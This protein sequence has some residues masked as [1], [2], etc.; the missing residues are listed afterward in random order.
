L[1]P[2]VL[3]ERQAEVECLARTLDGVR[4][5]GEGA[6]VLVEA[7]AGL[8]KTALLAEASRLGREAALNVLRARAAEEDPPLAAVRELLGPRA[9]VRAGAGDP[10]AVVHELFWQLAGVVRDVPAVI[11]L[12]DAHW[13]DPGGS[14]SSCSASTSWR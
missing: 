6:A 13:L 2:A 8:G 3:I 9:D 1:T 12:D 5:S 14:S 7:A 10:L 11:A 4:S